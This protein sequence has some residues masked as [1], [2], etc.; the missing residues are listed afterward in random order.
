MGERERQEWRIAVRLPKDIDFP[1]DTR[2][3]IE[4]NGNTLTIRPVVDPAAERAKIRRLIDDL[5]AIDV[6]SDGV[7]PRPDFEAPDRDGL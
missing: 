5:A 1:V 3:T 6:P 2:V 4:R 7:Q